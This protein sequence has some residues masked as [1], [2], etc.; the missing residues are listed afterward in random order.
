M[1]GVFSQLPFGANLATEVP[2]A[3][4]WLATEKQGIG[5]T[6]GDTGTHLERPEIINLLAEIEVEL[7]DQ[8]P[9]LITG[10]ARGPAAVGSRHIA[11]TVEV[12]EVMVS[13]KGQREVAM[14]LYTG[15]ALKKGRQAHGR[16]L[17]RKHS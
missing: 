4:D 7:S 11:R 12:A 15:W 17:R 14:R 6:E 10:E 16:I 3:A 9:I 13:F 1:L 2:T 8:Q 5:A